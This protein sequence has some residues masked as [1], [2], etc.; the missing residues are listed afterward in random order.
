MP[1]EHRRI[2][3]ALRA[4]DADGAATAMTKHLQDVK[5]SILGS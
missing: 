5:P 1:Q 2:T 4:R 3:A